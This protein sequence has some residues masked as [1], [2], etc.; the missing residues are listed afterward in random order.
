M[1]VPRLLCLFVLLAAVPGYSSNLVLSDLDTGLFS[2]SVAYGINSSDQIL[3]SGLS[4]TWTNY[5]LQGTTLT[6]LT[7][8]PTTVQDIDDAGDVMGR[9]NYRSVVV[10]SGGTT[11][12]TLGST[13]RGQGLSNSG[14]IAG[15]TTNGFV[16]FI[17]DGTYTNLSHTEPDSKEVVGEWHGMDGISHAFSWSGGTFTELTIPGADYDSRGGLPAGAVALGINDAG[18]IVGLAYE[19]DG[20]QFGWLYSGGAYTIVRFPGATSTAVFQINGLGDIVGNYKTASS[21]EHAFLGTA[22]DSGSGVLEPGSFLLTGT[23]VLLAA[24]RLKRA[25]ARSSQA[26]S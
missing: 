6:K 14:L 19:S 26:A 10:S 11:L 24:L 17:Y 5:V 15:V 22:E 13:Y 8:F 4:G 16:S 1:I 21:D 12:T 3:I 20:D 9:V 7:T 2:Q 23:A 18:Q 25:S